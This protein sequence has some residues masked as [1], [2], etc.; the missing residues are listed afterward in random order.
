[1]SLTDACLAEPAASVLA[2]QQNA[3]VG[4][5]DT[6]LII[7]DGPIGCLHL[8]VARA[9]G[10][11]RVIVAGLRRLKE[12]ARFDPDALIDAALQDT[13]AETLRITGGLGADVAIC[14]TPVASTQEQAVEAVRKRG[15]VIL[16]GGLP[17]T[18]PMTTLN[19]NLIHY[20]ELTVAGAFSYPATAHRQALEVIGR[21]KITPSKYFGLTV[22]LD[23]IVEGFRAAAE[24]RA[25]K[26]L[27]R[28]GREA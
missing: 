17:K 8:E 21:G 10:A 5:A 19:S 1:V 24:G 13:V 22:S 7:G 4:L 28:P 27:V 26:V 14:A 11:S 23:D 9:R 2:A 18:S 12:A 15:K 3:G 25:L 16:F 6:V 20:N